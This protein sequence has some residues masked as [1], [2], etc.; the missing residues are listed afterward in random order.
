L[1]WQLEDRKARLCSRALRPDVDGQHDSG[2]L[3]K[4]AMK[5][6]SMLSARMPVPDKAVPIPYESASDHSSRFLEDRILAIPKMCIVQLAAHKAVYCTET[7]GT[8]PIEMP[9]TKA[10]SAI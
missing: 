7:Y 6:K 1:C 5:S 2:L 10:A 3:R 9:R 4:E 8:E